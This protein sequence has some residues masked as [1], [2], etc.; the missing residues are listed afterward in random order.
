MDYVLACQTDVEL[1]VNRDEVKDTKYMSQDE[2]K[3][4]FKNSDKNGISI[5]PW[6]SYITEK[7]LYKWWTH[8]DD[9]KRFEEHDVIHRA[10]HR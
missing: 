10:G 6:F 9:I 5:T 1:N 8:L 4:F 7:L 3:E 2:L